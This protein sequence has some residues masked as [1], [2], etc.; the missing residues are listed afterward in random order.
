MDISSLFLPPLAFGIL[1]IA[2]LLILR[3]FKLLAAKPTTSAKAL[4][5]SY[6][7][8]EDLPNH[9]IQPDYGQFFPFAF[10]FTIL[11][12]VALTVTTLPR[13]TSGNGLIAAIYLAG[14][15]VG[16]SILYRR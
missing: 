13:V 2:V 10:F 6:A 9:R 5:T 16:L 1:L 3:G 11:H 15:S 4:N 14:A 12:V 8:G 7:C